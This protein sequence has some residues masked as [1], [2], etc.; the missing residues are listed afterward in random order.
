MKRQ[1]RSRL[2]LSILVATILAISFV[3]LLK[4]S[5]PAAAYSGISVAFDHPSFAGTSAAVPITMTAYGGP[6]ADVG[7]N[8]S[9]SEVEMTG[10]NNTGWDID[11]DSQDSE[12]GIFKFNVTM[13]A[14]ADQT[15]KVT[16][17]VTSREKNA[18]NET[19]TTASFSIRVV[20]PMLITAEV[21]NKGVVD[22][23]NATALIYADGMLLDTQVINITAGSSK[24][25][26]YNWTFS[27][28]ELGKHVV[29]VKVDEPSNIVEFSDGNNEYSL[30]IY[31]GNQSNPAGAILT[32]ALIFVVVIFVLTY[33][34][35]PAKRGKKL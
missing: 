16:L 2:L 6:A 26:S 29:T 7:G 8:Y 33:L 24:V 31:V 13:P 10:R 32:M 19:T 9:Y 15:V 34:Q 17:T 5:Q 22:V 20:E 27:D 3:G 23:V 18:G 35:K 25:I 21:F 28:I 30:T 1:M 12:S 14:E 4:A 11:F